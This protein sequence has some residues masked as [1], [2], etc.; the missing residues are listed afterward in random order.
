MPSRKKSKGKARKAAK[1]AKEKESRAVV[2]VNQRQVRS[3]AMQ[4]QQMRIKASSPNLCRHGFPLLSDVEAKIYV[5]FIE[6][7]MD[8]FISQNNVAE[9]FITAQEVTEERYPSM[10]SSKLEAVISMLLARGTQMILDG[11][12]DNDTTGLY[13]ML[14]FFFEDFMAVEVRK[15]KAAPCPTKLLELKNADDHTLV[16][17]CRKRIPCSCLD[18][19]YNEVKSVKKMG[20][21]CNKTCILPGRKVE[22]SKMLS[23]TQC[24]YA[25]TTARLNVKRVTGRITRRTAAW[26]R[27]RRPRSMLRNHDSLLPR[28]QGVLSSH[29]H[30]PMHGKI[31]VIR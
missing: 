7:F 22:R 4:M 12:V 24:G 8:T 13:A 27:R 14:A 26:L 21:C 10:Y 19:K 17:F 11:G 31:Y 16:S 3:L 25:K 28:Q 15:T 29:L 2:T 30:L 6:T 5:E 20:W 9:A 18:E 23:C 1:E